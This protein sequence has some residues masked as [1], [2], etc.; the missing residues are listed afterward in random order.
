[1]LLLQAR[2]MRLYCPADLAQAIIIIDNSDAGMLAK[3]RSKALLAEYGALSDRVRFV[4][5][6][7]IASVPP[8]DGWY[9]QQ[10]LKLMVSSLVESERYVIFYAKSH[11]VFHLKR[12]FLEAP[13]GRACVNVYS[14]EEHPLRP[15]LER[16]LAFMGS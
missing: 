7:D 2:S 14:Y 9:K 1:M 13:D 5:A 15:F 16:T 10:V 6:R 4:R 3:R 11:F 8:T 12:E